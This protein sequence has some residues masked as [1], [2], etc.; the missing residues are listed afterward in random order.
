VQIFA[1]KCHLADVGQKNSGKELIAPK[2]NCRR[3]SKKH[4]KG[5]GNRYMLCLIYRQRV[6]FGQNICSVS[7]FLAWAKSSQSVGRVKIS[8]VGSM[9]LKIFV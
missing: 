2:E 9:P 5:I 6:V 3:L 7:A 4:Q 1:G 8:G